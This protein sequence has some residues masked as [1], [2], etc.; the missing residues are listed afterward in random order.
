ML[1]KRFCIGHTSA[2]SALW[3]LRWCA[4]LVN[5]LLTFS[6]YF[7][8]LLLVRDSLMTQSPC[9]FVWQ[10][11]RAVKPLPVLDA[12]SSPS[13]SHSYSRYSVRSVSGL[14][15]RLVSSSVRFNADLPLANVFTCGSHSSPLTPRNPATA[16]DKVASTSLQCDCF[17]RRIKLVEIRRLVT[18]C[19]VHCPSEG[20]AVSVH[21]GT[22]KHRHR[23][24]FNDCVDHGFS[25]IAK[26]DRPQPYKNKIK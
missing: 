25:H 23:Q 3:V 4:L 24:Q 11:Y 2:F 20:S 13:H 7:S 5:N 17:T 10:R 9:V 19:T 16:V 12:M 8:A 1:W 18:S 22:I 15:A 21:M 26:V 6:T 14:I